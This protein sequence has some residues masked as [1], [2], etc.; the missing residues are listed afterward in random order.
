[1]IITL[2]NGYDDRSLTVKSRS[3]TLPTYQRAGYKFLGWSDGAKQYK[4]GEVIKVTQNTVFTAL[5]EPNTAKP[6]KPEE[7]SKPSKP[8]QTTPPKTGDEAHVSIYILTILN[9]R[10]CG[11]N[12]IGSF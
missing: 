7:P 11:R 10:A 1:M 8:G 3:I 5:W 6:E 12:P 9:I 2:K 4:A